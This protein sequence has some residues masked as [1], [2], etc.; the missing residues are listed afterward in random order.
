MTVSM[1][2][3]LNPSPGAILRIVGLAERRGYDPLHLTANH[4]EGMLTMTMTV[5]AERPIGILVSQLD[6]IF[7]MQSVEILS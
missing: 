6:K 3:T 2:L 4:R 1:K 7:G 5:K